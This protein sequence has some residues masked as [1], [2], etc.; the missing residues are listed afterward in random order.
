MFGLKA[1]GS[2]KEF[3]LKCLKVSGFGAVGFLEELGMIFV[4]WH[5]RRSEGSLS[6]WSKR[7]AVDFMN[8]LRRRRAERV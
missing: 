3:V 6:L 7:V 4:D 8:N 5:A 1:F 2:F